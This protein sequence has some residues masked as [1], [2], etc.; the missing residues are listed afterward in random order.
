MK[1]RGQAILEAYKHKGWPLKKRFKEG[2]MWIKLPAQ[3]RK[4][5]RRERAI[6]RKL[7][8]DDE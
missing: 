4:N 3:T 8:R 2:L 6:M 7:I 1:K 5:I